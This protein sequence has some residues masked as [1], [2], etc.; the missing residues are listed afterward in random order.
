MTPARGAPASQG[1]PALDWDKMEGLIPA[2]VQDAD[3]G[4]VLMLGYMNAAALKQTETSGRVTFWSRSKKRLWTKGE[5][6]GHFLRVK[7]IEADCDRDCLL[8]SAQPAGPVCHLGTRSCWGDAPQSRAEALTFLGELEAIIDERV[9]ERPAGSYTTK[10]MDEG[11]GRLAQKVGEEGGELALAAVT[12]SDAQI[13]GEA[14]DL[15]FH[16]L[17]LLKAKGLTLA[18]VADTLKARH[19][20]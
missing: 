8:I 5:T 7:K 9:R 2:I 3:S 15:L 12:Q 13:L 1:L 17:L 10:L 4:R 11:L 20:G 6:S 18:L 14:A 16:M 19:E